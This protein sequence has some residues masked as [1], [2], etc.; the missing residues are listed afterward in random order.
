MKPRVGVTVSQRG[1]WRSFLMN[2]LA[3]WRA[4]AKAV[5][6]VAGDTV[7]LEGLS[8]LIIGG[9]DDIGAELYGG[10]PVPDVRIDPARDALELALLDKAIAARLPV[11]G[12][13]RGAQILN[14]HLGGTLHTE[15]HEVY[16][17]ASKM[18]TVLPRKSVTL[19]E[20]SHLARLLRCNPC[21]VNALHHQSIDRLGTGLR[22]VGRDEVGVV[23]AVETTGA[24]FLFGVQWHPELLVLSR[25]Q[26]RLYRALAEAAREWAETGNASLAAADRVAAEMAEMS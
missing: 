7:T 18:R 23:Q 1:G 26:Q 6:F 12:I 25:P 3:L 14:V 20:G 9:G 15:I 21:R 16:E 17:N 5:R 11:L 19:E 8:G 24:D 2:R 22:V 10:T 4:G 13:C